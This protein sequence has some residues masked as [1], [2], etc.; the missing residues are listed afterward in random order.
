MDV[1]DR[2]GL[3]SI[4][5]ASTVKGNPSLEDVPERAHLIPAMASRAPSIKQHAKPATKHPTQPATTTVG[6][7]RRSPCREPARA[8]TCSANS[9]SPSYRASATQHTHSHVPKPYHRRNSTALSHGHLFVTG[10]RTY[11]TADQSPY[12]RVAGVSPSWATC[13]A[14]YSLPLAT[15]G[16][17]V[18][19]SGRHRLLGTLR[20]P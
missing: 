11:T 7:A 17:C 2:R 4:S 13:I 19:K 20:R 14:G 16:S 6:S 5:S 9:M 1:R 3:P 18:Y 15:R 8:L 10:A 12:P